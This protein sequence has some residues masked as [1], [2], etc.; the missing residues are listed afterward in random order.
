MVKVPPVP[1]PLADLD[2]AME[3]IHFAF[4]EVLRESDRLL[5]Q[6]GFGRLHHRI[7]FFAR[8]ND[9]I[10]VS[11]LVFVLD[12]TKQALHGPLLQLQKSR[13]VRLA[14]DPADGR[15]R[16][17]VLTPEGILFERKISAASRKRYRA[18][19]E[20]CGRVAA[21]GWVE[22]MRVLGRGQSSA[23]RVAALRGRGRRA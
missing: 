2:D 10:T 23:A 19:F 18:A 7:L 15:V 12:V 9:G 8:R 16:R 14:R 1:P 20:G 4:R 21:H 11:E 22:V 6:R 17:L 3:L 13:L 5:T